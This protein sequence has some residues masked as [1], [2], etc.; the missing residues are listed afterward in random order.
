M[1]IIDYYPRVSYKT[2]DAIPV[3][4]HIN[5]VIIHYYLLIE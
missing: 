4:Q 1:W 2:T 5:Y 3:F